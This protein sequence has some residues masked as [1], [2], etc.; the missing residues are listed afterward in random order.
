MS[1][2]NTLYHGQTRE[3][4][5]ALDGETK[6]AT[7]ELRAALTNALRKIEDLETGKADKANLDRVEMQIERINERVEGQIEAL[8]D[9]FQGAKNA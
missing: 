2:F 6:I 9:E 8:N 3:V 1:T 5:E 7:T 4:I